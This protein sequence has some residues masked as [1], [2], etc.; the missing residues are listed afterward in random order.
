[1]SPEQARGQAV[2]HRS[3]IFSF[4]AVL[5]EMATGRAAFKGPSQVETMNAVINEPHTP[6]VEVSKKVPPQL[7]TLIDR[8]LA[9]E[10]R[11]SLPI[12]DRA[13][14]RTAASRA[15]ARSQ[16]PGCAVSQVEA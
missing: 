16:R 12:D 4:G 9:K 11:G 1:M 14:R 15:T 8:A 7:A 5:Y 13:T 10:A 2:D 6:V 3:D